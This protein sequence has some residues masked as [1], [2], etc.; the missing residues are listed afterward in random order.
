MD[1]ATIAAVKRRFDILN[2]AANIEIDPHRRERVIANECAVCYYRHNG[3]I[4]SLKSKKGFCVVCGADI[5][6]GEGSE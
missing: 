5:H 3:S 2:Y 4:G 6:L 1:D